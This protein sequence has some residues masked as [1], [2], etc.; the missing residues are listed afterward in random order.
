M[1]GGR[2][3]FS[4]D[5]VAKLNLATGGI[6]GRQAGSTFK[7]FTLVTALERGISPQQVYAA[8]PSIE[9][10]VPHGKPWSVSNFEGSSYGSMT[11]EQATIDSVNTVYAQ[12]VMRVGAGNVAATAHRMGIRSTLPPT[13][14]ITLGTGDVNTVALVVLVVVLVHVLEIRVLPPSTRTRTSA[15]ALG[16]A[17]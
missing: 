6:T 16:Q 7:A 5:P 9:I 4:K 15:R 8:P 2:G 13:P 11:L 10:Q 3:Y 17:C 14:S 12:V 1:V